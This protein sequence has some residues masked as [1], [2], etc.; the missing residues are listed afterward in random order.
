VF[1][2]KSHPA[3]TRCKELIQELY[4]YALEDKYI[5]K[6]LILENYNI[7]MAKLLTSGTDVWLNNPIMRK[8]AC[9]TSG[10][11]AAASGSLNLSLP[12]G[13]WLEG[14]KPELGWKIEPSQAEDFQDMCRVESESLYSLLENEIIPLYYQRENGVYSTQWVEK[15][16]NSIADIGVNFSAR[17]MVEDYSMKMYFPVIRRSVLTASN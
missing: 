5:G 12:D 2:G 16:K 11:K 13:W 17:R 10:M 6:I 8:E 9:G 3:D 7:Y 15:M 1:A 14:Y 4:R